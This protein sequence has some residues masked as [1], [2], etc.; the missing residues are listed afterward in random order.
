MTTVSTSLRRGSA[1]H[2]ARRG[3]IVPLVAILLVPLLALAA[4][5][6]NSAYVE[7]RRTEMYIAADAA[8]RAGGRELT[9]ARSKAAAVSKAKRLASMND[10]GGKSLTLD[11]AD[12]E[13][14][15][16]TRKNTSSRYIFKANKSNPTSIRV[17]ARRTASSS[18]GP[19]D[20]LMPKILGRDSVE[21]SQSSISTQ[22]QVDIA[23]VID[24][25]GSM[26]YA[27]NEK[28]AFPPAPKAAPP[29]WFFCDPAPPKSRW[30]EMVAAVDVFIDELR[31]SP[32]P[33]RVALVT[34]ADSAKSEVNPTENYSKIQAGLNKYTKSL[35][36][37]KTNVG[38]GI[39]RAR[40][41]I[42]NGKGARASA[43]KVL[44][45]L[46]DGIHNT[47]TNPLKAA[48][49]AGR[50]G[51]LIFSVT[52]SNEANKKRMQQVASKA[53]GKHFHASNGSDLIAV[54]REIATSLPTLLTD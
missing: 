40:N 34:Y 29:G 38:G 25:S 52:F 22:V 46:T 16:A 47:G 14:G 7:L 4:L 33:E 3:A 48:N 50:D 41:L 32:A 8:A 12:I 51:L 21:T 42:V 13:F 53:G 26:A 23:L 24:R 1:A 28:A 30:R 27:S 18:D 54:F 45:V 49:R 11:N 35:C 2:S 44:V 37:G 39:E 9:M 43:A 5:A 20:L 31:S 17:T 6:I 19:I 15:V 10:V 36:S